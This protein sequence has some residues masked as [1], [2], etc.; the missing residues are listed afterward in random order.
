[1]K[2]RLI[3]EAKLPQQDR[4]RLLRE[5]IK[6]CVKELG[7]KQPYNCKV[8]LTNDKSKTSSYAHYNPNNNEIIVYLRERSI[9]DIMR[10]LCHE[11][12]HHLQNQKGELEQDSGETGSKE[13]NFANQMAGIIMRK[14][15]KKH[16]E[17]Y[18]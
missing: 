17:I 12:C 4:S 11:I 15:G 1:M 13:E 8:L 5:F 14:F 16:P 2:I 9:G 18:E 6:F 10:S 7:L 3:T